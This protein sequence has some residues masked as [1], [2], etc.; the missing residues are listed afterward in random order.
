[1]GINLIQVPFQLHLTG[2][3]EDLLEKLDESVDA[4]SNLTHESTLDMFPHDR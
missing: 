4:C 3:P 2:T 1:M